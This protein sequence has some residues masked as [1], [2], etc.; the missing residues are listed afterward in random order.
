M[1][2]CALLQLVPD[3]VVHRILHYTGII[4]ERHTVT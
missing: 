4:S 1:H 3:F 2:A